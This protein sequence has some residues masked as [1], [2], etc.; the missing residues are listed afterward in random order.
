M[1]NRLVKLSSLALAMAF[2]A[3]PTTES[4]AAS[5]PK[6]VATSKGLFPLD[7]KGLPKQETIPE[8]FDEMDYQGAVQA[9]LWAMPQM[10][11]A[12]Q[13]KMN[14]FYG[15]KGSLDLMT[16]YK[17]PSL[18]G[19]TTPN[20][21]VRYIW[22]CYNFEKM[23]PMVMEMPGGDLVG[24]LMDHQMRFITDVGLTSKAG[25]SPETIVFVGPNQNPPDE[26]FAKGWRIDYK[27]LRESEVDTAFAIPSP[28]RREG[29]NWVLDPVPTQ[30]G[31]EQ[32]LKRRISP[33]FGAA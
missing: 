33:Q 7:D 19:F 16:T 14:E 21:I 12:G 6:E 22:N 31:G 9:Y 20:S 2:L 5:E 24:L 10:A 15:T 26:A 1:K 30:P 8:L 4:Y 29:G 13:C 25:A 23:G 28:G 27:K 17:D 32:A 11:I 18:Y 3:V